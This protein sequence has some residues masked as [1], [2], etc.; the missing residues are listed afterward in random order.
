MSRKQKYRMAINPATHNLEWAPSTPGL[1]RSIVGWLIL[2]VSTVVFLSIAVYF[3][4]VML[5]S[6]P[7]IDV[8]A[9]PGGG[10][11][12]MQEGVHQLR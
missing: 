6:A 11:S 5:L 7:R 3:V 12:I 8:T 2:A 9:L 4:I 10:P 1:M